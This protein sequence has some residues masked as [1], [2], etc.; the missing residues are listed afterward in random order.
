MLQLSHAATKIAVHNGLSIERLMA[1]G[2]LPFCGYRGLMW[3]L[4]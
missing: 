2:D 4:R 3:D 1:I